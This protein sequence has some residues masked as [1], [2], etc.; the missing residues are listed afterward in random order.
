MKKNTKEN[1]PQSLCMS[2][3]DISFLL[4]HFSVYMRHILMGQISNEHC[5]L[6]NRQKPGGKKPAFTFRFIKISIY[7]WT[8][9]EG[10]GSVQKFWLFI[11]P[12]LGKF[13]MRWKRLRRHEHSPPPASSLYTSRSCL[14][15]GFRWQ[16][17]QI[18]YFNILHQFAWSFLM[19]PN[20][21]IHVRHWYTKG[22]ETHGPLLA[23][24]FFSF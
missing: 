24:T 6:Q 20:H 19:T 17:D 10:T 8:R 18:Y 11:T 9:M 12:I 7:G 23:P 21:V 15:D 14:T 22:N 3:R 13:A 2:F 16:D 1:N 4:T 5:D